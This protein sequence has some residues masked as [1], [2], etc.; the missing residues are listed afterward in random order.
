ML[1]YPVT[2]HPS[3]NHPSYTENAVG[4]GLDA[5]TGAWLWEQYA[6]CASPNDPGTSPAR[7]ERVPALPATLVATAEYDVLRDDGI[8][9]AEK[10][11]RAGVAVT[12]IHA[13]DM[14]HNFPVHPETVARFPQC[15][16]AL[17]EIAG[18]LQATLAV[19]DT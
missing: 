5:N 14:H 10:L 9:Y 7:L 1:L 16:A 15:Q 18:W 13:A 8:A 11:K 19:T 12:H 3:A 4:Y 6:P 2:D 17:N